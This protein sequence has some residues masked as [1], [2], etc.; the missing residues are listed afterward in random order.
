MVIKK[1]GESLEIN[2]EGRHDGFPGYELYINNE[3]LYGHNPRVTGEGVLSLL[4]RGEHRPRKTG[5]IEP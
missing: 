2:M 5:V 3:L 1:K 4:G